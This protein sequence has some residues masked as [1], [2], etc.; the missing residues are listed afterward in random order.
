MVKVDQYARIRRAHALDGMSIKAL[1]RQFHHSRRKIREIL[2]SAEPKPYV[3]LNPPPTLLEPF[4]PIIDAILA[5]DEQAP[6]KQRH[7]AAKIY[8][9]L[10]DEHQFPGGYDRVRLY[11]RQKARR[12]RQTFIPLDHDPGQRVECDFGHIYA[13][14]PDGRRQVPVLMV[15]WAYSNCPFAIALPSERTEAILHGM[16]EAFQFFGC[17]PREVWWDNPKT[18]VPFLFK[19]RQRVL[20][21]RYA[22]LASHYRF[23]PL[24]CRVRQPQEKPR[25]EGRVR[26]LQ[27]DW[28]TPVPQARDLDELNAQLRTCAWK[29]RQ[30]TQSGQAET[31]GQRFAADSDKALSLPEPPFDP[32]IRQPAQ[33]D[34]Y[35]TARFDRNAYSVPRTFAFQAVTIK[36][37]ID[38]VE[39]VAGDQ[40]VAR[41]V[42]SYGQGEQILDPLHYLATLGR[43]PA[44]LDHA[45]VYRHWQLPPVFTELRGDLERQHGAQAGAR[46][47]IRVLQ[48]LAE[49]SVEAVQRA[50][51]ISRSS[52]GHRVE[53]ILEHVR[54]GAAVVANASADIDLSGLPA[55]VRGLRVPPPNLRQF[56]SLLSREEVTD[57]RS[58]SAAGENQPEA[59]ASA[60]HPRR[61]REAGAG[62]G[63]RQREL[64]AILAPPDR[65]GS[66]GAGDQCPQGPHQASGLPDGQGFRYLRLLGDACPQ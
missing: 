19:G 60:D 17:V 3:R 14:F 64:R 36:G 44:A 53:A 42:R 32:C 16:V 31:I 62:G 66:G 55:A 27:R 18:V 9:R 40:V 61:V 37:Y 50:I 8:R 63:D 25:V 24:F 23:E 4:Q 11:V 34:K 2:A 28:C 59:T 7:T 26:F 5:A 33:V 22:A 51:E 20:N 12:H 56:D 58:E 29:D 13:E 1:A 45:N 15:T 6:P 39:I 38:R 46:Q 52:G 47:F 54:R 30:R 57:V 10:R 49:H 35:Q 48:L 21:E 43:R 65:T 41:H